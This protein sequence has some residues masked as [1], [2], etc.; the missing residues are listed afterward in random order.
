MSKNAPETSYNSEYP[1]PLRSAQIGS[2]WSPTSGTRETLAESPCL[3]AT[4]CRGILRMTF[5]EMKEEKNMNEYLMEVFQQ[6]VKVI[7]KD[8]RCLGGWHF[9]SIS[10]GLQD[11]LSDVDPVFLIEDEKFE[12]FDKH[13]FS[14]FQ[15]IGEVALFW[16][17][18]FNSKNLKNYAILL[19]NNSS[20]VQYDF[21]IMNKASVD[22]PFCRIWY[23]GC[24]E[25]DI[26]FDRFGD[27]SNLLKSTTKNES[28]ETDVNYIIQKYWLFSYII[29]KYY[30][31]KDIFKSLYMMNEL[32]NTHVSLLLSY[33]IKK[34]WGNWANKISNNIS[35]EK[36]TDLLLYFCK[37]DLEEIRNT[38]FNVTNRFSFHAK[39]ICKYRC[40]DYP[41]RLENEIIKYLEQNI[42]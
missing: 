19:K 27:I 41:E 20:I 38:V 23:N 21:T 17:E 16:P 30:R 12:E 8:K 37:G 40:I 22:I 7:K 2:R 18:E 6:S 32:F 39:E 3:A 9:G 36:Q 10:R 28:K 35:K 4:S 1:A 15:N 5:G 11:D 31:R 24:T 33:Y 34:D 13:I 25:K 29:V 14:I 42:N 26:I